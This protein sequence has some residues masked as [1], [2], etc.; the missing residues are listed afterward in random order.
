MEAATLQY[1]IMVLATVTFV[2]IPTIRA[3]PLFEIPYP[4]YADLRWEVI[5][6]FPYTL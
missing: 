5:V 1:L 2:W 3:L 4:T 6:A